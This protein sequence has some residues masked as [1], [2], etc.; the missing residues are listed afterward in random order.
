MLHLGEFAPCG[1]NK[2]ACQPLLVIDPRR[3]SGYEF[4]TILCKRSNRNFIA[5]DSPGI[6]AG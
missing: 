5:G 3:Q 4:Q 1:A 6:L 2:L